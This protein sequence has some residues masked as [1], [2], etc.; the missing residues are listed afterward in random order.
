MIFRNALRIVKDWGFSIIYISLYEIIYIIL[1]FK[2]N[3]L[4]E[5]GDFDQ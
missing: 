2:G 4:I 5:D 3:E 1:G